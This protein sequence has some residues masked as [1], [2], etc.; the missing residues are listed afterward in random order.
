MLGILRLY[1]RA[2]VVIQTEASVSGPRFDGP[3]LLPVAVFGIFKNN[4]EQSN[5]EQ[6]VV[7]GV[8]RR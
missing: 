1:G 8:R 6:S 2:N 5:L 3:A 7:F 4:L